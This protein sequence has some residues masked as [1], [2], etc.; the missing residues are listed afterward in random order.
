MFG[1]L[2]RTAL[3]QPSSGT[4]FRYVVKVVWISIVIMEHPGDSNRF[5]HMNF[6]S[7]ETFENINVVGSINSLSRRY[8]FLVDNTLKVE[9]DY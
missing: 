3:M 7:Y 2:R 4:L 9:K 1:S 5:S 6:P 8:K